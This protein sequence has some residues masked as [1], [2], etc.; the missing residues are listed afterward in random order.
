MRKN[1][2]KTNMEEESIYRPNSHLY[3]PGSCRVARYFEV[4]STTLKKI[5]MV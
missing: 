2:S 5:F 4:L 1:Q 3:D